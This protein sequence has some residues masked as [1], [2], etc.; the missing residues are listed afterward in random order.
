MRGIFLKVMQESIMMMNT[1]LASSLFCLY[2]YEHSIIFK[3]DNVF[4]VS[5]V[6]AIVLDDSLP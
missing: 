1:R 4:A 2:S 3:R 6:L 5:C